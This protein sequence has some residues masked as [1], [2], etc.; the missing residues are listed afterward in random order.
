[1]NG[2]GAGYLIGCHPEFSGSI[3]PGLIEGGHQIK[4]LEQLGK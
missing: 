2:D 1:M 4:G 3:L